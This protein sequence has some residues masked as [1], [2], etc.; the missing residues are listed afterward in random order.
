MRSESNIE[1]LLAQ[2]PSAKEQSLSGRD[3]VVSTTFLQTVKNIFTGR[4]WNNREKAEFFTQLSV[5]VQSRIS[6]VRAL[7]ILSQQSKR[8]RV[9]M[10]IASLGEEIRKGNSL[11]GAL[12]SHA[13]EFDNLFV[14]TAEVGQETGRL[15][16]VLSN[17]ADHLEKMD[18]LKRRVL[19]ALAYPMV[20]LSVAAGAVT[21]LM[22]FIVPTFAEMFRNFQVALPASTQ[23]VLGVS[24]AVSAYGYYALVGIIAG[25]FMVRNISRSR[26]VRLKVERYAFRLPYIGAMLLKNLVARFCRTL[27][28]LLHAQV[29]LVEALKVTQKIFVNNEINEEIGTIMNFVRQGRAV[30]EPL[31]ESKLFPPMVAQMIAVGE[32]ASELDLMLLKVADYYEKEIDAKIETLSSV[33]EPV[34]IVILGVVV[35][36]ILI[37]M[38]L[39]MFDLVNITSGQ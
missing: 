26:I 7:E 10:V 3:T 4:R 2:A 38:Y 35:A 30:A 36:G 1:L 23:F 28:T 13:E 24:D 19:Q 27:G 6:L 15:P 37:A 9:R 22:V 33:I 8:D 17:L 34:I 11:A 14:A 29:A 18:A 21:F 39:P 20:V 25:I 31:F 16:E 5:M 32:E 12:A